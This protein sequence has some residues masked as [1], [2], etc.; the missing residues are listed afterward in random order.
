[1]DY[2][3]YGAKKERGKVLMRLRLFRL[4]DERRLSSE[5]IKKKELPHFV[6]NKMRQFL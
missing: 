1:M 3:R 5:E 4:P 6:L 2:S